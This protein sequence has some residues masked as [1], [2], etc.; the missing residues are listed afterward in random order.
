MEQKVNFLNNVGS[1]SDQA[2]AALALR[3]AQFGTAL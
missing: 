1:G 2:A 3:A